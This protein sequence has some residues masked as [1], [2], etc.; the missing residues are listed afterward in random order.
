MRRNEKEEILRLQREL[1]IRKARS[2]LWE[3]CKLLEPDFYLD[4]RTYLKEICDTLQALYEGTLINPYNNKPYKKLIMNIPPRHGKSRTLVN[5]TKW[6]LGKDINNRIITASYNDDMATDFSRYTRDGIKTKKNTP[7]DYDF[8]DIFPNAKVKDGNAAIQQWALEGTYFSYKGVGLGGGITGKGGNILICDD[9]VK[10]YETAVN[11]AALDKVWKWYTGTF[12]S[13][14]ESDVIEIMNMTRWAKGDPCGRILDS[15]DAPLWYV[16]H[17]EAYDE[18]NDEMLCEDVLSKERYLYL[19]RNS[20][21]LVFAANYHQ[22]PVDQKGKLYKNLKTYSEADLPYD[23]DGNVNFDNIISYT[24]TADMGNDWLCSIT[25][26][27]YKGQL[28]IT[29]VYYTKDGMEVTEPETAKFFVR[30]KVRHAKIESNNGGRGFARN[31]ERLLWDVHKTRS[32]YVEWFHQSKNKKARILTNS[33]FVMDNVFFPEDWSIKWKDFY[34]DI[35]SYQKEAKKS[36]HDDA[37]D[38][39]TG[40]CEMIIEAKEWEALDIF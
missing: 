6:L 36:V 24:D 8:S 1:N 28:Y 38:T 31:V 30:N 23:N 22:S 12:I 2:S 7:L 13:R 11:E 34:K 40:L 37:P 35:N 21:P 26:G 18:L 32:V 3:F 16:L 39:L 25:A 27:L 15:E 33:K 10:D 20:D 4:H 17:M 14:A 9:L 5:Y 19:K 29:D